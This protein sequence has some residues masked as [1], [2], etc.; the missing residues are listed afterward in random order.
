M[1]QM[2]AMATA[3]L[4]IQSGNTRHNVCFHLFYHEQS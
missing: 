1:D 3:A 4:H 2:D